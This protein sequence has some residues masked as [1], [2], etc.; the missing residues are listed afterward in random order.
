MRGFDDDIG[1]GARAGEFEH[2]APRRT[3]ALPGWTGWTPELDER[4]R[5]LWASG[6]STPLIG[7]TLK[8]GKNAAVGRVHRLGLAARPSPI[9]RAADGRPAI[10]VVRDGLAEGLTQQAIAEG[11]GLSR[12]TVQ[13]RAEVVRGASAANTFRM[14]AT[15]PVLASVAAPVPRAVPAPPAVVA[16]P[17][18][19]VS[20]PP[21][22]PQPTT[23]PAAP[24]VTFKPRPSAP[25]CWPI[26]EP[27][28][29]GFRFC[30]A[31]A[32]GGK[33]YCAEH[34]KLAYEKP[35]ADRVYLPGLGMVAHV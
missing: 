29:R 20:P 26:G 11:S 31:P 14:A 25:C 23:E 10:E 8:C 22:Q 12:Q 18:P 24:A 4:L 19:P 35:R 34:A 9:R 33:P 32:P 28:T 13:R 3:G 16:R 6:M 2:D 21:A 27:G 15:L 1:A 17:P 5:Q 7:E 30:D